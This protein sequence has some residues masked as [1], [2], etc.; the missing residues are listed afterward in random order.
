MQAI[1]AVRRVYH[2]HLQGKVKV[3]FFTLDIAGHKRFY[4]CI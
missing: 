1:R 2:L 4:Y 3:T